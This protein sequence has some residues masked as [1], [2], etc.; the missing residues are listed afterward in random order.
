MWKIREV[1][2][3]HHVALLLTLHDEVVRTLLSKAM[4][5]VIST[6]VVGL[7]LGVVGRRMLLVRCLR[8]DLSVGVVHMILRCRHLR[9]IMIHLDI[10]RHSGW[11]AH[12]FRLGIPGKLGYFEGGEL[13]LPTLSMST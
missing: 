11:L 13:L 2:L 4:I 12:R 9:Q 6:C 5:L 8:L 7:S 10:G 1:C 3:R